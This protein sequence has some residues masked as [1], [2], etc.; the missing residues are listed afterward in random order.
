MTSAQTLTHADIAG[1]LLFIDKEYAKS[2]AV[3]Y[4]LRD[5]KIKRVSVRAVKDYSKPETKTKLIIKEWR[6]GGRKKGKKNARQKRVGN[7]S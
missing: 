1:R 5:Y 6:K 2:F 4:M 7:L 3:K